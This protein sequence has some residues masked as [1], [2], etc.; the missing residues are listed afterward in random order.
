MEKMY[1]YLY[2]ISFITF[3]FLSCEKLREKTLAEVNDSNISLEFYLPRYNNFLFKTH[4]ADNLL[5]RHI[6][7]NS[8]I[9]EK[10]IVD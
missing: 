1:R 6:F 5:N 9:D 3:L 2:L 4:Q 8:L 7:L 10:L